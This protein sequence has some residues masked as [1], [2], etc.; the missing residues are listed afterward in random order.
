LE[1]HTGKKGP[2]ENMTVFLE[3]KGPPYCSLR[4]K[5]SNLKGLKL[6]TPQ[7]TWRKRKLIG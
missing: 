3:T 5:D 2:K 6:E 4:P 7:G 1:K